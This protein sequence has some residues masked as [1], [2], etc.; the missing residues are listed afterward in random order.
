MNRSSRSVL[1]QAMWLVA[2]L[3]LLLSS[4]SLSW[5]S[6]ARADYLYPLWYEQLQIAEHIA[7]FAP[8]NTMGKQGLETLPAHTHQQ[9]F[10]DIRHAVHRHGEGL[11]DIS[12]RYADRDIALLHADEIVHLEDVA[13]LITLLEKASDWLMPLTLVLVLLL[14]V[15]QVK[16]RWRQQLLILFGVVLLVAAIVMTLG[17][18]H[19]FYTLHVWIFPPENPW[20]FYY[21][22]SLMTTLM[23]APYLFGAI[24]LAIV[25]GAALWLVG[26]LALL[27]WYQRQLKIWRAMKH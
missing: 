23:K 15:A 7:Q 12:Y 2:C 20:F 8:Q 5:Q 27:W 16:I 26:L 3:G 17:P 18:T 25:V 11:S 9:L 10:R 22:D 24:A 1:Q 14:S 13:R 21:Q 6:L 19:V 4:L